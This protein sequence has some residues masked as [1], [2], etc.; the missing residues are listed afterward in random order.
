M[1]GRG[2]QIGLEE[3][4]VLLGLA[5]IASAL[6]LAAG[7]PGLVGFVG[8]LLIVAGVARSWRRAVRRNA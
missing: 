8:G 1:N 5:L 2:N 3:W 6:W 7:W 4:L